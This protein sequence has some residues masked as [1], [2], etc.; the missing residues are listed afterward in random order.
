MYVYWA[1]LAIAFV[2]YIVG[3]LMFVISSLSVDSQ[4]DTARMAFVIASAAVILVHVAAVSRIS[5]SRR[6]SLNQSK[7]FYTVTTIVGFLTLVFCLVPIALHQ[8]YLA[9]AFATELFGGIDGAFISQQQHN[10]VMLPGESLSLE[11]DIF[12]PAGFLSVTLAQQGPGVFL[13]TSAEPEGSEALIGKELEVDAPKVQPAWR[14]TVRIGRPSLGSPLYF[15]PAKLNGLIV[16]RLN[17]SRVS[18]LTGQMIL[19][20]IVPIGIGSVSPDGYIR[21]TNASQ[22]VKSQP[23]SITVVPLDLSPRVKLFR[24]HSWR[25]NAASISLGAVPF[26]Y[27]LS[28]AFVLTRREKRV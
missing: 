14:D 22:L 25:I 12:Q 9:P 24:R 18:V 17:P 1:G 26:L 20:A 5:A 4:M 11:A 10:W 13:V 16:N 8:A 23:F 2:V 28:L 7:P 3:Q 6:L 19:P 21:V 27:C 15:S